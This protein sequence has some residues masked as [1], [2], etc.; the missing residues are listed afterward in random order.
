M[1]SSRARL[2]HPVRLETSG[3]IALILNLFSS[4]IVATAL[5]P[6]TTTLADGT[7]T[8]HA[9]EAFDDTAVSFALI[10]SKCLKLS[11]P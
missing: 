10:G 2:S 11:H 7:E 9:D 1:S 5:D 4:G 8:S 6:V 3:L